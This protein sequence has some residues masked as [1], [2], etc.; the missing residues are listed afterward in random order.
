M[1]QTLSERS[2]RIL[3]APDPHT[4][5]TGPFRMNWSTQTDQCQFSD[6]SVLRIQRFWF[7]GYPA[8]CTQNL[9]PRNIEWAKYWHWKWKQLATS[10]DVVMIHMILAD[11]IIE[12][13]D[14][15]GI[16]RHDSCRMI[17][18]AKCCAQWTGN[19]NPI[20]FQFRIHY[21]RRSVMVLTN[22]VP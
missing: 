22:L 15:G 13:S 6:W 20:L 2:G 1:Y 5:N 21:R 4:S 8:S 16:L 14:T 17:H 19:S 9:G 10:V 11:R 18:T 3:P 7:S 12:W